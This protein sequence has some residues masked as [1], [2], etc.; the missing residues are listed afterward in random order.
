MFF[1]YIGSNIIQKNNLREITIDTSFNT[2]FAYV[3]N[4]IYSSNSIKFFE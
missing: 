4:P 1:F 2:F 3:K